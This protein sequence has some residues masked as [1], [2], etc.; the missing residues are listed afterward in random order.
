MTLPEFFSYLFLRDLLILSALFIALFFVAWLFPSKVKYVGLLG[1]V[2]SLL[3][4]IIL[5]VPFFKNLAEAKFNV[6]PNLLSLAI[7][8]GLLLIA[9]GLV[10]YGTSVIIRLFSKDNPDKPRQTRRHRN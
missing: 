6:H 5:L 4:L 2:V 7:I 1:L 9:Y 10:I 3:L 8:H